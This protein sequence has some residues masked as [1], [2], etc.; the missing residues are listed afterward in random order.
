MHLS[1]IIW[2]KYEGEKPDCVLQNSLSPEMREVETETQAILLKQFQNAQWRGNN[3]ANY[4][5]SSTLT[6]ARGL[7]KVR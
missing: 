1:L 4:F 7:D 3:D 6:I 2:T 5:F